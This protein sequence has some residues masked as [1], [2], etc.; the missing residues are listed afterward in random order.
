MHLPSLFGADFMPHGH[1]FF[2]KPEILWP[3][4][5]ADLAIAASYYSIPAALVYIV[6]KRQDLAFNW[7]F[8]MFG[9]FI[10]ACGTTHAMG[11]WTVW[12]GVYRL[13]VTIKVV[14]AA[15]SVATAIMLWRLIPSA[16][17]LPS[18]QDLRRANDRL[19]V[20]VDER[21]AAEAQVRRLNEELE[22]TVR[23]RTED[24]RRSNE[25]LARFAYVA[26]HDL[27]EPLRTVRSFTDLLEQRCGDALDQKA[28][29]YMD[30]IQGGARS[31]S[32]LIDDLLVYSRVA[33][34]GASFT[35]VDLADVLEQCRSALRAAIDESG[36]I[37]ECEPLP[38]VDGDPTLLRML[39]QNLISNAI[40]YRRG[41]PP[42]VHVSAR[43]VDGAWEIRV[44][45][46]GIG[47]AREHFGR[48]FELF[49]RLH[50]ADEYDGSGMGLAICK[51]VA[52]FHGSDIA[53]VSEV[54]V[55]TSFTV[56]LQP[57][58]AGEVATADA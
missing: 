24:L 6:R 56:R 50:G 32:R 22:G 42:R 46:N 18:A 9:A 8:L 5:G 25:E 57:A 27:Q 49:E 23:R 29:T 7:M 15:L 30:F 33:R 54:G 2:W 16:L 31:M 20:E 12:R 40:K 35:V 43:L 41:S 10:L 11:I 36:A 28:R 55:G 38:R 48:I 53:V 45:D 17:A 37:I 3:G 13:D 26:S 19:Q 4:V 44:R 14:T 1:C 58:T 34:T 47:I 21:A 39:F 51:K 52:E